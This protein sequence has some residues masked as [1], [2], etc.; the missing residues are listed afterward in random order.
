MNKKRLI[1]MICLLLGAGVF[2]GCSIISESIARDFQEV[3]NDDYPV[4]L[5]M[6]PSYDSGADYENYSISIVDSDPSSIPDYSGTDV[7]ELNGNVPL[8]N[9]YDVSNI[10][11][12][13]FSELDDLGRCGTAYA[14]L[15]YDM[16]PGGER[17]NIR[18]VHPSGWHTYHFEELMGDD[19]L[20]NR[21][22]L[23][24][25]AMT[26]ENA[27]PKNLI[28]GTRYFNAVTMQEYELMV[29][30][31]MD[32]YETDGVLYR[33][34]PYFKDEE[35]VARGV[36]MEAYSVAD[37]GGSISYHV[38]VYNVQPGIEIDYRTGESRQE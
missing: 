7:I 13:H 12:M 1:F 20:Y 25:Y 19:Y 16:R 9:E 17:E 5:E 21:S 3:L 6:D 15:T 36:E 8:F 30:R 34:S 24:A 27:N 29:L 33:V 18:N 37:E 14:Y 35:L 38:F 26:G 2:T 23:L 10:T 22:H 31:Y 28:T 32:D 11:G 4:D